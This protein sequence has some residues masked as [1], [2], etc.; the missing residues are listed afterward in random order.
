M[1]NAGGFGSGGPG[2]FGG[3]AGGS[4][5]LGAMAQQYWSALTD[6]MRSA[7]GASRPQDPWRAAMDSWSQ[8]AG[9]GPRND[10]SDTIERFSTQARQW[11]GAMQQVAGQFAGRNAGA[12][13]IASAWKDALGGGNVFAGLFEGLGG[14]GQSGFDQWYAQ[15][16][17]MMNAFS[18]NGLI[19]GLREES[20][21]WLRMPA[22]GL[23]REHQ[24]RWQALAEAQLDLQRK[25]DDYATLMQEAGKDAFERF[26]R[27]LAERSEPGRQLQSARALFD[28]WIDAAEEAYAEIALSP[29]FRR[30]YGDL[31]NAQM[32]VRAGVQREIEH[33]GDLF[34][35]PGRTEVD[36]AH[37]RIAELERQVRRLTAAAEAPRRAA[38]TAERSVVDARKPTLSVVKP[39]APEQ[40][41]PPKTAN[42]KVTTKK[43]APAKTSST[44]AASKKVAGGKPSRAAA[45]PA[46]KRAPRQAIA[47]IPMP[48][49]LKP[50]P[51]AKAAKRRR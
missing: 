15:I 43:A 21:S 11:L 10:A 7:G 4:V 23:N 50:L 32:R 44:K 47:S 34:G 45:K 27:K 42:K 40:A 20:L 16:A 14:R 25:N 28:L 49:P 51:P 31:V 13:E 26:E 24:E 48:E 1:R 8:F 33:I 6:A 12:G 22:F 38:P 41:S 19:G 29:R 5:D 36:A 35:L 37:R 2:G 3:P 39:A 17:P 18:A 30:I 9:G 46:A